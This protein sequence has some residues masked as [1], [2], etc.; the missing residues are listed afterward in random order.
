MAEIIIMPKLGF[1]MSVGKLVSWYKNEG[2]EVTKGE[3]VFAVETDK[4]NIDIEATSD[5]IFKKKF[6]EEGDVI[7]VTL[8]IAIIAGKDENI[9]AQIAECLNKLGKHEEPVSGVIGNNLETN[10]VSSSYDFDVLVIGGGPGGYVAAIKAAQMGKRTCLIEKEHY[11]GV[12]LNEGCIPTK[13]LLRSAEALKE[14][15]ESSKFGVVNV[16]TAD[17]KLDM[18]IVQKRKSQIVKQLVSGVEG[19]LRG[20]KVTTVKGMGSF[21]D[22]NTVAVGDK[23]YTAEKIIIASG[24]NVKLLPIKVSEKANVLTSKEV[25]NLDYIPEDIIIIGGGV[26]G[27]ELACFLNS[28]GTKV[29]VVEFLDRI[30]PMVDREITDKLTRL[31]TKA[32]ITIYTSSKVMEIKDSSI[33][34]DKEGNVKEISAGTVLMAVGRSANTDGLNLEAAGVKTVKGSIETNLKLE[35]SVPNIYAI[36]DVNGKAM[37]AHTASMEGIIAVENICGHNKEMNYSRIPSAIFIQPEIACVGLTEEQAA[38][39]YKNIKIGKFPMVANGK[40]KV[41][42]EEEGIIKVIVDGKLG[43]ILGVHMFC[44]H[45]TDMISEAVAAMNLEAT[46]EE[47]ISS[48]HPHPTISE[49]IQEAFH[50]AVDKAIHFM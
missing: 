37:L 27:I 19:L 15:K 28:I 33:L 16:E 36:G 24:S 2:D 12:C 47:L 13:A 25:L 50:S 30:L 38:E 17:A 4:T 42:G 45:A 34:F 14:V 44:L 7:D 9:E 31:L 22:K 32:G 49:A 43:E 6:I 26:I 21:V 29:T 11:G 23:K 20:N 8:P 35:T 1:N 39:K 41:S 40:A 5:G 10:K 18:K 3:P 48:I 46:A